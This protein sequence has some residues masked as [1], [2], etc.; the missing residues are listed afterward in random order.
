MAE[1]ETSKDKGPSK[2]RQVAAA[3]AAGLI[4]AGAGAT[5]AAPGMAERAVAENQAETA[6]NIGWEA[7]NKLHTGGNEVQV[8]ETTILL[9]PDVPFRWL[10]EPD[11]GADQVAMTPPEGKAFELHNPVVVTGADG[12]PYWMVSVLKQEDSLPK[13]I[14]TDSTM[15]SSDTAVGSTGNATTVIT[16]EPDKRDNYVDDE[17]TFAAR[18]TLSDGSNSNIATIAVVND[19]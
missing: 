14:F 10:S 18:A 11:G 3:L 8:E 16:N 17:F 15:G 5:I 19:R 6:K 1:R 9:H 12:K 2:G 7:A 13:F 4:G